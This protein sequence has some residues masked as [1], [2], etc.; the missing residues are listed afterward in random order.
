VTVRNLAGSDHGGEGMQVPSGTIHHWRGAV[1]IPNVSVET[2]LAAV[3]DPTAGTPHRQEDVL[4]ARV[5]SRPSPDRLR[6]FLKLQRRAIVT[7][8]YNTEHDVSY[9]SHGPG[10]ASSRSVAT[11]I[12]EVENVGGPD[13]RE[14][15]PGMD[16]GFLWG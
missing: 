2:V 11:R 8:T 10:R 3:T 13:E 14:C 12:A 15:T 9:R 5:L 16:R 4:E 6:L 1:F 7:A